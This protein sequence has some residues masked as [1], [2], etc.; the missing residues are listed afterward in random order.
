MDSQTPLVFHPTADAEAHGARVQGTG[1]AGG[2]GMTASGVRLDFSVEHQ[3]KVLG[4]T[5]DKG[6]GDA[7]MVFGV[8]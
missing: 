3:G 8:E 7:D 1:A 4:L 2:V 5:D 6:R